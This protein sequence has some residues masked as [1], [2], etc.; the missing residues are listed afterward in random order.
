MSVTVKGVILLFVIMLSVGC[1]SNEEKFNTPP[2]Y[3]SKIS[4]PNWDKIYSL[5]MIEAQKWNT[6]AELDIATLSI[7]SDS[8]KEIPSVTAI[9]ESPN[10]QIEFLTIKA[11]E[12]EILSAEIGNN[13]VL[14]LEPDVIYENDWNLNSE[15]AWSLFLENPEIRSSSEEYFKCTT[16]TLINKE[17]ASEEKRVMWQLVLDN[18]LGES[19]LYMID[20]KTGQFLGSESH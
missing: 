19:T 16:L 7:G 18:C 9:F 15:D 20:A 11:S 13:I 17:I 1:K 8:A 4:I 10:N 5:L 2:D 3:I 12:N 14:V 6:E